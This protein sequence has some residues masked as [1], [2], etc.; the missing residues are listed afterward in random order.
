MAR[1]SK[2]AWK[3]PNYRDTVTPALVERIESGR[4]LHDV[5][6][7]KDMPSAVSV[8]EW[9]ADDPAFKLTITRARETGYFDRAERAVAA[10]KEASDPQKGRLAFDAER[11]F[12]GKV[13]KAFADK[14]V[15]AGDAE[16]PIVTKNY[17]MTNLT[18]EQL[19]ALEKLG[20]NAT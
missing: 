1:K 8:Y 3:E 5:C 13:S 18:I 15:L 19:E 4:S 12:L 9:M 14:V 6:K 2:P 7:D 17:D 20:L 11:W 10:A 16:N